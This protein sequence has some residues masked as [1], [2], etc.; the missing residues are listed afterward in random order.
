VEDDTVIE[1]L[2]RIG[3]GQ[4]QGQG[5]GGGQGSGEP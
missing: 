3:Q 2:D 1:M 4:G 5:P